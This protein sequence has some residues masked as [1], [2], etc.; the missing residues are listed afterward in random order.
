MSV[1]PDLS[2]CAWMQTTATSLLPGRVRPG[3]ELARSSQSY[4]TFTERKPKEA[5]HMKYVVCSEKR[6]GQDPVASTIRCNFSLE[7]TIFVRQLL[8]CKHV[9]QSS[10]HENLHL[11]D[12]FFMLLKSQ[13]NPLISGDPFWYISTINIS[14]DTDVVP[15]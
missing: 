1:F 5:G 3:G 7:R 8:G 4:P 2:P 9:H 11:D 6:E 10:G 12:P 13:I 15:K 14:T